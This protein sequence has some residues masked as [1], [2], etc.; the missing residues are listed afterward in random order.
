M[1]ESTLVDAGFLVALL[2]RRDD[3]H[4]WA[5]EQAKRHPPPWKTCEAALSEAF[6]LLGA[7]G[8]PSLGGFL[9]RQAVTVAFDL[10]DHVEPVLKLMQK[11]A[12]LPSSLAD[13]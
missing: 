12:D 6:Y 3:H 5:A 7:G 1:A 13:A 4:R 9:R 2:S 10:G 8:V 11:Y